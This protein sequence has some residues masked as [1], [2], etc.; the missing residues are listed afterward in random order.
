M[1]PLKG[2][3]SYGLP[4]VQVEKRSQEGVGGPRPIGH[5]QAARMEESITWNR[6]WGWP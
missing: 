1:F 3:V 6:T 2:R 5:A 4:W